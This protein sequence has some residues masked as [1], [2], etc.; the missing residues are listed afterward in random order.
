MTKNRGRETK[1][2]EVQLVEALSKLFSPIALIPR[3]DEIPL[4]PDSIVPIMN[5]KIRGKRAPSTHSI[6]PAT[7]AVTT[8]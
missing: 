3:T 6:T 5:P 7:K 8:D 2:D 4:T 1:R